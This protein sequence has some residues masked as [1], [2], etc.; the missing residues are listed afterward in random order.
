MGYR[1]L[2]LIAFRD[3]PIEK[4]AFLEGLES[5][6]NAHPWLST[7]AYFTPAGV[8][9]ML[10]D[11]ARSFSQGRILGGVGNA[12]LAGAGMLGLG[13]VARTL[14][15]GARVASGAATGGR[16]ANAVSRIPYMSKLNPYAGRMHGFADSVESGFRPFSGWRPMTAGIGMT[17]ADAVTP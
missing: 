2:T 5:F 12:L 16:V 9:M 17:V 13:G 14:A 7:A 1:G 4:R 3:T 11:S 8:P 6:R 10:A 15:H